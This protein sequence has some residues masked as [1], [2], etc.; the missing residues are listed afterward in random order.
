MNNIIETNTLAVAPVGADNIQNHDNGFA[1]ADSIET[2]AAPEKAAEGIKVKGVIGRPRTNLTKEVVFLLMADGTYLR[3]SKGKPAHD[4]KA[5]IYR[6]PWDYNGKTLPED[7]AFVG[8]AAVKDTRKPKAST[9]AAVEAP[10][11]VVPT[12]AEMLPTV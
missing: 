2:P 8:Q 4:S 11:P 3:R 6:V 7:C 5:M 12:A 9:E 10:N 1:V